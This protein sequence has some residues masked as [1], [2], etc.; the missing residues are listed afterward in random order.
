[1]YSGLIA[2]VNGEVEINPDLVNDSA[3]DHGW[4]IIIE[5]HELDLEN[6]LEPDEYV[7]FLA[8]L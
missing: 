2:E 7:E 1:M 6:L 4:I 3:Y 5:P 8:E